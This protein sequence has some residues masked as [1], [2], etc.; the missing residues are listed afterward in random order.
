MCLA[1]APTCPGP[2]SA[3]CADQGA[4]WGRALSALGDV[5]KVPHRTAA[6]RHRAEM[7]WRRRQR[8]GS[9]PVPSSPCTAVPMGLTSGNLERSRIK[10][11]AQLAARHKR[12]SDL[13]HL[14]LPL[15]DDFTNCYAWPSS[16][17]PSTAP[18][19]L[20]YLGK[21]E[22]LPGAGAETDSGERVL[23]PVQLE[24]VRLQLKG[25]ASSPWCRSAQRDTTDHGQT[26]HSPG[27]ERS[28]APKPFAEDEWLKQGSS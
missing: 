13:G 17:T 2:F 18:M 11:L 27:P 14:T 25:A 19:G 20:F 9:T 24:Q 22:T 23:K 3:E 1:A 21:R 4:S 12:I 8:R 7:D 6:N 5:L 26:P 16:P 28:P 10:P 15:Q